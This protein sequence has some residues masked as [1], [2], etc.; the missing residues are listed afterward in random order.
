MTYMPIQTSATHIGEIGD[1]SMNTRRAVLI[2]GNSLFLAGVAAQ[3]DTVPG[4]L[5]ERVDTSG[6]RT[7]EWLQPGCPQ[8][9]IIDLATT[10]ADFVLHCLMDCPTL[11]LVGLDLQNS[12]AILLNSQFFPVTTL[13]DLTQVLQSLKE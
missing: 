11:M 4:L 10:R 6:L 2:Y 9:L 7:S 3:L 5:I 12:R 13:Q 8:I 1:N